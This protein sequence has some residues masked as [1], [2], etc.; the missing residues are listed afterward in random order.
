MT[1]NDYQKWTRTTALYP[2]EFG[3]FYTTLGLSN[4]AGEVAGVVKKMYRDS[5]AEVTEEIRDKVKK[6]LGDV[7]WYAARVADEFGFYLEQVIYSNVE[8]LEDRLER[9][10]IKGSGDNR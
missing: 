10:V 5:D 7:M 6:E 1:L 4:E 2:K 8:K 3:L 9:N